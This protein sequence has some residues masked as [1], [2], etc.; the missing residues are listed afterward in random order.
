MKA[1]TSASWMVRPSVFEPASHR[2]V[3]E[4]HPQAYGFDFIVIHG[5]LLMN[6]HF[7]FGRP[8]R[9]FEMMLRWI[10]LVPSMICS[11][12]ASRK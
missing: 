10:W 11:T 2:Q 1:H 8:S 4:I 3:F 9:L 6:G 12:L 7:R 5:G